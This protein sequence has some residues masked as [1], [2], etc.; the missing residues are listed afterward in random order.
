MQVDGDK[1]VGHQIPNGKGLVDF[2]YLVQ[3]KAKVH[4]VRRMGPHAVP[5]AWRIS[6]AKNSVGGD[7]A[8]PETVEI[9]TRVRVS[10]W[11]PPG[12][13]LKVTGGKFQL[14]TDMLDRVK[15]GGLDD[16]TLTRTFTIGDAK[17]SVIFDPNAHPVLKGVDLTTTLTQ[18]ADALHARNAQLIA[19]YGIVGV[20]GNDD[21]ADRS[22][23]F[24]KVMTAALTTPKLAEDHADAIVDAMDQSGVPFDGINFDLEVDGL[25]KTHRPAM[26][27][28]LQ[29]VARRM[30][31][32]TPKNRLCFFAPGGFGG[33]SAS[34]T[35]D[36]EFTSVK[37][38]ESQMY[39]MCL[40]Q[41]N[42]IVRPQGYD[43]A[44]D[45]VNML[46]VALGTGAGQAHIHPSQIQ[47]GIKMITG[48]GQLTDAQIQTDCDMLR[49]NRVGLITWDLESVGNVSRQTLIDRFVGYSTHLNPGEAGPGTEGQPFQGPLGPDQLAVF[50][51]AKAKLKM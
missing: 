44:S 19:G 23:F 35:K 31:E 21:T 29:R 38:G 48:T 17:G 25:D 46:K 26:Q 11:S 47:L 8:P 30:A 41:A 20:P 28:F 2:V 40:G 24:T 51:A 43:G 16:I 5:I 33:N 32:G 27:R 7:N 1:T 39:A 18:L 50:A 42:L 13:F 49:L 45:H 34:T 10:T 37:W 22:K 15:A 12:S 6:N 4:S 9:S 36:G 3:E 14:D